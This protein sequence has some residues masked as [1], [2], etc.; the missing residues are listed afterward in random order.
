M[1]EGCE[2]AR[3][4]LTIRWPC[5]GCFVAVVSVDFVLMEM[6]CVSRTGVMCGEDRSVL[7]QLNYIITWYVICFPG[8]SLL[9]SHG[10]FI[11]G[12]RLK[13]LH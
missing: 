1:V 6:A 5:A 3:P 8:S 11:S 7:V 13:T 4:F 12:E 9:Y 10:A 2:L